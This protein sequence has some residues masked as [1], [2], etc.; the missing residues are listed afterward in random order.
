M[1]RYVLYIIPEIDDEIEF[2]SQPLFSTAPY[3]LNGWLYGLEKVLDYI[4]AEDEN[5]S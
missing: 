3:S 4:D 1:T 5:D 2:Y